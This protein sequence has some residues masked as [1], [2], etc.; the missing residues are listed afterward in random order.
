LKGFFD[1]LLEAQTLPRLI[2]G[3]AVH[4]IQQNTDSRLW[5]IGSKATAEIM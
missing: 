1:S 5:R 3:Q 2:L 4:L